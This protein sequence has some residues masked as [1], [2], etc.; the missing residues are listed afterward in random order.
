MRLSLLVLALAVAAP[1]AAQGVIIQQAP[2]APTWADAYAELRQGASAP[3]LT[4]LDAYLLSGASGSF[5]RTDVDG[6]RNTVDLTQ[7]GFGQIA[8]ADLRGDLNRL[9][10]DQVGDRNLYGVTL[11]GSD[12]RQATVQRG[13]DNAYVMQFAGSGLRHT[14]LQEGDGNVAIQ[15]GA[16]VPSSIVQRSAGPGPGM[17]LLIEHR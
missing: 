10:V 2:A 3:A 11:L 8:L 13:D 14:V 17:T 6:L 7:D 16:G 1:V 12:N 9:T 15:V 4:A 5:A